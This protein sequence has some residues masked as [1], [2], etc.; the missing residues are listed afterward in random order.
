MRA[1]DRAGCNATARIAASGRIGLIISGG[2][3]KRG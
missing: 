2:E 1:A 3:S